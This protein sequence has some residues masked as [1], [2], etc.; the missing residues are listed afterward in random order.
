MTT[1]AT[2]LAQV[3][4]TINQA[5]DL[6][7]RDPASVA[8]LAVSK[9]FGAEVIEQA[10]LAGQLDFGENYIQEALGKIEQLAPLRA[11][12]GLRWHCIGPIQSNKT[13]D[14]AAHFDWVHT[15]DRFKIAQRLS[16]QRPAQLPPLQVCIQVNTDGGPNKSGVKPQDLAALAAQVR[17]LAHLQLRGLM[18]IPE[19]QSDPVAM[20]AIHQRLT[21]LLNDLNR[22]GYVLDTLSMGMSADI[23]PAIAAG[24]TMVRVGTA[25]FGKR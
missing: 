19:P 5:C 3:R 6:A 10:A 17:G 21:D 8:L 25:I 16:E 2:R 13:R 14:V 15:L 4:Q 12:L 23:E 18:A 9:T 11:A 24:S 20:Q 1:L 22:Q 7:G